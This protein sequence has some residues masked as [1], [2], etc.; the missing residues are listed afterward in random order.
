MGCEVRVRL[1]D[2]MVPSVL[3]LY[4]LIVYKYKHLEMVDHLRVCLWKRL[5]RM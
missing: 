3:K 2:L 5:E 1:E 4:E